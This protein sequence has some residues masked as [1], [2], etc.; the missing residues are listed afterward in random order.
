MKTI[1]MDSFGREDSAG[2]SI[3]DFKLEPRWTCHFRLQ[4][5]QV[6][7]PHKEWSKEDLHS[8]LITALQ[9]SAWQLHLLTFPEDMIL[10][11]NQDKD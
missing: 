6:G 4:Q 1:V 10:K 2:K 3:D 5:H 7:C 11:P 9:S 8:A